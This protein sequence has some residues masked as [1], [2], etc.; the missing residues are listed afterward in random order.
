MLAGLMQPEKGFIQF[1]DDVWYH[2]EKNIN[3][4]PQ[5]RKVGF[6]FQDYALFP[7]MTVR[8]NISFG[9]SKNDDKHTTEEWLETLDLVELQHRRSDTLSG[10]QKQRVALA[11]ALV[12]KPQLLL[13][14]EPFSALD[15]NM[16]QKL[17]DKVLQ[18]HR[19]LQL[20][21]IFVSH[22]IPA[23]YKMSDEIFLLENGIIEKHGS[24]EEMFAG[25][26]TTGRF[27][28][29]GEVL[30]IAKEDIVYIVSV[31]VGSNIVKIIAT[32]NE[33]TNIKT[34]DKILLASKAF[35]PLF[36]KIEQ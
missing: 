17:Q 9:I 25:N 36:K 34:G 18:L 14:D 22:D 4:P 27:Q 20:T 10:G 11:R 1:D 7:N 33:I 28:F 16:Q 2:A 12:R 35:N 13:L 15:I 23:I 31:L 5:K 8:E 30:G 6:V 21:T 24:S 3:V 26:A 19:Q 29:T 32:E